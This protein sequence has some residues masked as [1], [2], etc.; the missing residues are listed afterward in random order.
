MCLILYLYQVWKFIYPEFIASQVGMTHENGEKADFFVEL[1][2]LWDG[3][4]EEM[5]VMQKL[6]P[7]A[8]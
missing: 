4:E 6:C 5:Q 8:S 1:V 3:D 2:M 7:K